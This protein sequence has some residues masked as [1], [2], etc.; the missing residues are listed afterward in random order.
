V[1]GS[2]TRSF[3]SVIRSLG[4]GR[5]QVHVAWHHADTPALRSRYVCAAHVLPPYD[6]QSEAWKTALIAL[7]RREAFDLVLPCDGARAGSA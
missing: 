5:V 4:R 3:L 1:L 2:D 7:M 6:E